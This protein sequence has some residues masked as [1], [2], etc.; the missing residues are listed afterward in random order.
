VGLKLPC[1]DPENRSGRR[2]SLK[3]ELENCDAAFYLVH[4]MMAAGGEYAERDRDLALTFA[5]AARDA[6]VCRI[7]YLGGLGETCQ[8]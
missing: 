3:R 2:P 5:R 8:I 7:I 1:G 6:G 4:S